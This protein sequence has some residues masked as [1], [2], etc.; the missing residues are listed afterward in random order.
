MTK[1]ST[2]LQPASVDETYVIIIAVVVTVI[3]IG[4]AAF[5]IFKF[6]TYV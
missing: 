3:G 2:L 1:H 6:H 5:L 4:I